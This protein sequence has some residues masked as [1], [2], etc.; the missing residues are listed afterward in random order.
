[1]VTETAQ[2]ATEPV[3]KKGPWRWIKWV[4]IVLVGLFVLLVVLIVAVLLRFNIPT[5]SA[6]LAAQ[7][8]CAGTFVSGRD[9]HH[10]RVDDR[11]QHPGAVHCIVLVA[12]PAGRRGSHLHGYEGRTV[13]RE[14]PFPISSA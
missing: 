2:P 7:T 12:R 8:V 11:H 13:S 4:L 9:G 1:M 14:A 3:K 10:R 6:G 5:N